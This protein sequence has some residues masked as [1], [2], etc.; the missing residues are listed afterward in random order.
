MPFYGIAPQK[1]LVFVRFP[2]FWIFY[3][4]SFAQFI[5]VSEKERKKAKILVALSA[6]L[7]QKQKTAES[8]SHF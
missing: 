3:T 1:N 8:W 6:I 2:S 7:K 4:V 5:K